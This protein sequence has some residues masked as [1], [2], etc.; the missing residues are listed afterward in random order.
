MADTETHDEGRPKALGLRDLRPVM[1]A[2]W[3]AIVVIVGSILVAGR[4]VLI[5]LAMAVLIWQLINALGQLYR[6]VRIRGQ[7][8]HNWQRLTLAVIT[9]LI[10]LAVIV[11]I[12]VSNVGQVAAAAPAYD[13][14]LRV[15]IPRLIAALHLP[16]P[17]T[18]GQLL[19]QI[20]LQWL[21]A[22]VTAALGNFVG[23][24][25]LVILYII[26]LLFE[27]EMFDRKID[28]LFPDGRRAAKVRRLLGHINRRIEAYVWIKTA[29]SLVV[30]VLSYLVLLLVGVSNAGFWGLLVFLLNFI[31]TIGSL[32]GIAF[33]AL[34][35]FLQF[36]ALP[37]VIVVLAALGAIQLV[38]GNVV[39]PRLF[40]NTLNLSPIV[41]IVALAL[42]GSLW[43][44]AGAFL[45]VPIT[46]IIMIICAQFEA[47]RPVAVL[48]SANGR[49][50]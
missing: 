36:A 3:L 10:A 40:G 12:I 29:A 17:P 49:I 7:T 32:A 31:P 27:Q 33:P 50:D 41:M 2:A 19:A 23:N 45:C 9:I 4:A 8:A 30:G 39:E 37:P 42:W 47:S 38:M 46:V 22:T 16:E 11:E 13:E 25:G 35:T 5:P 20:D 1:A 48:L 34:I 15:L 18:L 14:N 44:I 24:I 6:K 21:I 28:V 26:F 43:G